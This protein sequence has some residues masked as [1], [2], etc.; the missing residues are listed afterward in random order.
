MHSAYVN[1]KC[2]LEL[3]LKRH[4]LKDVVCCKQSVA[5][6]QFAMLDTAHEALLADE[7]VQ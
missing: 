4:A 5:E 3:R 2:L 6:W 7:A 1:V